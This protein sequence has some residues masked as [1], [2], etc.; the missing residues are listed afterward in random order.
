M[1]TAL[2]AVAPGAV[3]PNAGRIVLARLF[4]YLRSRREWRWVLKIEELREAAYAAADV[5]EAGDQDHD[6]DNSDGDAHY[7]ACC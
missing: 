5:E 1:A 4:G 3:E 7:L 6:A 2:T